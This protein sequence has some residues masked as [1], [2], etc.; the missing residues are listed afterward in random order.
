MVRSVTQASHYFIG[1][2]FQ[3]VE[4][5][6]AMQSRPTFEISPAEALSRHIEEGD[7]C[8]LFNNRGET[9]G[10]A[11]IIE[12]LLSGMIGT[13]K[14]IKDEATNAWDPASLPKPI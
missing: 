14:Q 7:L 5:L 9:F 13:Q 2:S 3:Q 1:S 12:G 10:Y 8:R 11:V 6:Q 4:R